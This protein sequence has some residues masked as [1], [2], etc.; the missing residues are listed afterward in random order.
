MKLLLTSGGFTNK[1]IIDEC[2]VSEVYNLG[3]SPH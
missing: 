3:K 2:P 1:S